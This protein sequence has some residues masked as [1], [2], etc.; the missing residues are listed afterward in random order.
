MTWDVRSELNP[1]M[2]KLLEKAKVAIEAGAATVGATVDVTHYQG[3]PA[4]E[5]SSEMVELLAEAITA[6]Y[7]PAGLHAPVKTAGGEDFHFFIKEKPSLKAG[8]FGLGCDL[9]PGIHHP[10]MTFNKNALEKGKDVLIYAAKK[11]LK[12]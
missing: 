1:T 9:T 12:Q 5:Y 7:G 2:V 3:I 10:A 8:Y 4:A 11:L 6:V